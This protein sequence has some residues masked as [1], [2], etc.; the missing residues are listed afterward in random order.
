MLFAG[1]IV[2]VTDGGA[3]ST[4]Y[5]AKQKEKL[6]SSVLCRE[7]Y[8]LLNSDWTSGFF[9]SVHASAQHKYALFCYTSTLWVACT[10]WSLCTHTHT[11][12]CTGTHNV[13][14]G[15]AVIRCIKPTYVVL[16]SRP[17]SCVSVYNTLMHFFFNYTTS[18]LY[19][20]FFS[21]HSLFFQTL[22]PHTLTSY[23][24][25]AALWRRRRSSYTI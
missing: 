10:L 11:T 2:S 14:L 12:L 13:C 20:C 8:A 1:Q 18:I 16:Y 6:Y 9:P 23:V 19:I 15:A 25:C 5:M 21:S 22:A 3:I 7:R 4:K 24:I 17:P